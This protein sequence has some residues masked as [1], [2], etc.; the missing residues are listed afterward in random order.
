MR[1]DSESLRRLE[2][3]LAVF[4]R[5]IEANPRLDIVL[6]EKAGFVQGSIPS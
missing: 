1:Y 2:Y 5:Y 4:K 6:S 3:V